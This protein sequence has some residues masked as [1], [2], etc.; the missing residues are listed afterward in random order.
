L[1]LEE[2]YLGI[3]GGPSESIHGSWADLRQHQLRVVAPG[4]FMPR[5]EDERARPQPFYALTT[6]LIPG[7][8]SYARSLGEVASAQIVERLKNL[9]TRVQTADELHE[10]YLQRR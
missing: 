8:V 10:E 6:L 3:F 2:A 1:G 7:L 5:F 9:A 4:R